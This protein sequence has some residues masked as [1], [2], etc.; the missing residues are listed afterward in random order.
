[1]R[2][3]ILFYVLFSFTLINASTIIVDSTKTQGIPS[4]Q[5]AILKAQTGDTIL[6]K[7]G[8]YIEKV[9][10]KSGITLLSEEGPTKTRIFAETGGSA[11]SF[12]SAINVLVHGFDIYSILGTGSPIAGLV[13]IYDSRNIKIKNCYIHD[14]GNDGDCIKVWNT[15]DLLIESC[16][17]W[18]P[19]KRTSQG[20]QECMDIRGGNDNRI[21]I[22]GSWFFHKSA[23][24]DAIIFGKGGCYNLLWENNIFGPSGGGGYGNTPVETGH[25]N[26]GISGDW[27][28]PYPSERYVVRNN[29]FFGL[30]GGAAVGID[31]PN[32]SL[33]Y[34]N[35]FYKNNGV[36]SLIGV[37]GNPGTAG[38]PALHIYSFNN[39]FYDNVDKNIYEV[40]DAESGRNLKR[41]NNLYYKCGPGGDLSLSAESNSIIDKNPLFAAPAMALFVPDRGLSQ[42]RDVLNK[43]KIKEGSPA[44]NS[45]LNAFDY[46]SPF[47]PDSVAEM[48][49]AYDAFFSERSQNDF[50]DMGLHEFGAVKIKQK[51]AFNNQQYLRSFPNPFYDCA[52]I[53]FAVPEIERQF[54]LKIFSLQGKLIK[55]FTYN[56]DH[57][58]NFTII[59]DGRDFNG[60]AVTS[61]AYF[62]RLLVDGKVMGMEKTF[63]LK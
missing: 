26:N 2:I 8:T 36:S 45:G 54:S 46:T 52:K 38:G 50:W 35:V 13:S 19:A 27:N 59:W 17:V 43:F 31:G 56:C 18:N 20:F 1:M 34:N 39:I 15:R 47:H 9:G 53:G 37:R 41:D 3:K 11:L 57:K 5:I 28:P 7:P 25:H 24:G 14:A 22:R 55:D 61:G 23:W 51:I 49:A 48:L 62:Y 6:V 63:L 21:T 44:I 40:A 16:C 32:T 30:K 33:L 60:K 29:L 58:K 42:I 12:S 10:L 4:I